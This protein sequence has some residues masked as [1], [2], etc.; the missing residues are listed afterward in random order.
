MPRMPS[1]MIL[2]DG[3]DQ[4]E[5]NL[6]NRGWGVARA[7]PAKGT[8]PEVVHRLRARRPHGGDLPMAL[9]AHAL[10]TETESLAAYHAW[11]GFQTRGPATLGNRW[12]HLE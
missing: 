8:R 4:H 11:T 5:M 6:D 12:R 10:A 9:S 3:A 7:G 2:L 1:T